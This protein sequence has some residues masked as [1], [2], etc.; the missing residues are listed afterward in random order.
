MVRDDLV[1]RALDLAR[2]LQSLMPD[3]REVRGL[4][5][6]LLLTDARRATRAGAGGRLLLLAEQDRSRWNRDMIAEGAALV[7]GA[8]RGGCP[9][10][11]GVQA[12]IAALH[13][14]APSYAETDWRQIVRLYDVLLEVW[15]SPVV[16]LNRAVALALAEGPETGLAQIQEL[17]AGGRLA[18]YRYL[19]AAKADLLRRLGR[20]EEAVQ[21]YRAALA[22]TE[23]SCGT[24][25]PRPAH[26]R[27][28]RA[29][30][31]RATPAADAGQ[32]PGAPAWAAHTG[33]RRG[34]P[35]TGQAGPGYPG[36][37]A[38]HRA[39]GA[40]GRNSLCGTLVTTAKACSGVGETP[41]RR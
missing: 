3:E 33:S 12:A 6:L 20:G 7:P 34:R 21:A 13:A 10:R 29:A 28:R 8:L 1:E 41:S 16:A 37:Q 4:L 17:E 27:G 18:D 22:L 25:L 39:G 9:G 5:A 40:A 36:R 30:G 14:E 2:M 19:P 24:G 38:R 15:P 32:G 23:N 26:R 31:D 35:G 11:F